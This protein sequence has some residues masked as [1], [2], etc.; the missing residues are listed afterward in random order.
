MRRPGSLAAFSA[1]F[2]VDQDYLGSGKDATVDPNIDTDAD[3]DSDSDL[4]PLGGSPV[5]RSSQS[6]GGHDRYKP[7]HPT[8]LL[9]RHTLFWMMHL[10]FNPIGACPNDRGYPLASNLLRMVGVVL[11]MELG[12]PNHGSFKDRVPGVHSTSPSYYRM[13]SLR[14]QVIYSIG[15]RSMMFCR[16]DSHA[17]PSE[18][19]HYWELSPSVVRILSIQKR[20]LFQSLMSTTSGTPC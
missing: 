13:E 10:V 15:T 17:G 18:R 8:D 16:S 3:S 14:R 19:T 2:Q 9:E 12:I 6:F 5:H 4:R 11:V 20:L 7:P 1:A